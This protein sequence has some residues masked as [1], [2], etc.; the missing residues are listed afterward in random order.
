VD[1]AG[2][3]VPAAVGSAAYRVVQESL[4]N[5]MRHAGKDARAAVEVVRGPGVLPVDVTDA[6]NAGA[7]VPSRNAMP[8][9][10]LTGMRERVLEL[11]GEFTAGPRPSGGFQVRVRLPT[12]RPA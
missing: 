3:P 12:E 2:D 6:G 9:H 10:G 11:G 7:T 1:L 4:T 8:G 5:V